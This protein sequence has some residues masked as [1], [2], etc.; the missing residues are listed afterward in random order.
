M[1]SGGRSSASASPTGSVPE[2]AHGV[3]AHLLLELIGL[4]RAGVVLDH[5]RVLRQ[6]IGDRF[7]RTGH[8]NRRS[9]SVGADARRRS[10]RAHGRTGQRVGPAARPPRP[11]RSTSSGRT[12]GRGAGRGRRRPASTGSSPARCCAPAR[13]LPRSV[14]DGRD[15]RAVDRARLRRVRRRAAGRDPGPRSGRSGGPT[16]TSRR[17]VASRCAELGGAGAWR[18]RRAGCSTA[19]RA[20][21]RGRGLPRVADQGGGR[22]GARRRRRRRVAALRVAPPRSPGSAGTTG[23]CSTRSTRPPTCERCPR[24]DVPR[25]PHG[26]RAPG[27]GEES[28]SGGCSYGA[29]VT[30]CWG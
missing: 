7:L 21:H 8:L 30:V 4:A 26:A 5:V 9:S 29:T 6:A 17:P 12:P 22:L 24:P 11:A 19:R 25:P 1:S 28:P 13:R 27:R 2:L 18:A 10:R 15:R 20:S 14:R 16:S 23:R 3:G